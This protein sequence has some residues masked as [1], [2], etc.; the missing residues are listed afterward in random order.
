[1]R[2]DE[3]SLSPPS[4][5]SWGIPPN[6]WQLPLSRGHARSSLTG[7]CPSGNLLAA[8]AVPE[9]A[10]LRPLAPYRRPAA[11]P[12]R[13][14]RRGDGEQHRFRVSLLSPP[15]RFGRSSGL[16]SY[17]GKVSLHTASRH[18]VPRNRGHARVGWPGRPQL[19]RA[20][21]R[22]AWNMTKAP[23]VFS[24]APLARGSF[25]GGSSLE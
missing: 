16:R 19:P 25:A 17:P 18:E 20:A 23:W 14:P 8:S 11:S 9:R 7:S 6:R 4:R 3:G 21:S 22:D 24:C 10:G 15:G 12:P 5:L 1:M 13:G 2:G